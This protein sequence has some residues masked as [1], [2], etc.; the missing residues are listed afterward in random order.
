MIE[1]S[2]D[3]WG[4]IWPASIAP[5][6]V[7]ICALNINQDKV[8]EVAEDLYQ[9]LTNLEIEVLYDDRN[10]KAGVTFAEADLIG[11]PHRII[12][13]KKTLAENQVEYKTRDGSAKEMISL[14]DIVGYI[15]QRLTVA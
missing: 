3:K 10:E 15:Q 11:V 14:N 6:Q 4:P 2:H 9:E 12:I 5:F 13:S 7:Q 1:Q 8:G